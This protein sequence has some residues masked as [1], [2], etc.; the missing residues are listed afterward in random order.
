V[1]AREWVD[2]IAAASGEELLYADGFDAA[3][4]GIATKV[5][6]RFVVYDRAKVIRLLMQ[7]GMTE[8]EA[9]EYFE[10]NVAGAYVG[11]ATPAFIDFAPKPRRNTAPRETP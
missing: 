10:F 9:E 2:E 4:V 1:T 8:A 3:I 11:P 7:E 5:H 6:D